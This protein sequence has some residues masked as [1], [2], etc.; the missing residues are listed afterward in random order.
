[1][2]ELVGMLICLNLVFIGCDRPNC[3]TENSVFQHAEITSVEYVMELDNQI[4]TKDQ[5]QLTFWI[6]RYEKIGENEYLNIYV[7]GDK[8]CAQTRLLVDD[9]S[10]M[11][12]LRK[13]KGKAY[14]GAQIENLMME[15]KGTTEAPEFVYVKHSAI[16]D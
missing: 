6:R 10:T 14:A 7:Q 12:T 15:L 1:M 2:K 16:L 11:E 9:W 8:L 5:S 3:K 13:N 4:Q